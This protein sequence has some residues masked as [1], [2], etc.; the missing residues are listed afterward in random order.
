[1]FK[2]SLLLFC[3]SFLLCAIKTNAQTTKELEARSEYLAAETAYNAAN[4]DS[5]IRHLDESVKILGATNPKIQYLIVKSLYNAGRYE[6]AKTALDTY[7]SITDAAKTD[8][9]KYNE[10]TRLIAENKE[11][12]RIS[13]AEQQQKE[14]MRTAKLAADRIASLKKQE[15]D[16][17]KAA[18]KAARTEAQKPIKEWGGFTWGVYARAGFAL[19]FRTYSNIP[20]STAFDK[21]CKNDPFNIATGGSFEIGTATLFR[22]RNTPALR[23]GFDWT[24]FHSTTFT[25]GGNFLYIGPTGNV[26]IKTT[27]IGLIGTHIGPAI[28]LRLARG[29]TLRA[30][31]QIAPSSIVGGSSTGHQETFDNTNGFIKANISQTQSSIAL[32]NAYSLTLKYYPVTVSAKYITG[33]AT[34][35]YRLSAEDRS[36]FTPYTYTET[37]TALF[38]MNILMVTLGL[39][40]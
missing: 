30:A 16:S 29:F 35:S 4:Y 7:F 19:P 26:T 39:S 15:E 33:L 24:A 18:R 34:A 12:L 22:L 9:E 17:L 2:K 25:Q 6:E 14:E 5:A 13:V 3:L 36:L 20:S 38:D 27:P 37:Q 31:Y 28:G 10:M 8:A 1:M 23:L 32:L 21:W 11:K 40:F